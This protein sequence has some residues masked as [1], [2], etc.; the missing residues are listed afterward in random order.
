MP[1]PTLYTVDAG[2]RRDELSLSETWSQKGATPLAKGY[3]QLV[4]VGVGGQN[5]LIGFDAD[6]NG[7]AFRLTGK[8]PWIAPVPSKIS[9]GKADIVEPFIL[10]MAPY[11]LA[12]E[13][14]EGVFSFFPVT[15]DLIAPTPPYKFSHPRVPLTQ[16][17]T[18]TKPIVVNSLLYIL[19]YNYKTGDVDIWSLSVTP[20]PQ[21]GSP[22]GTPPL[23]MLPVWVHQWA[24]SW[25]RFAFFTLGGETFFFKINF[26]PKLNVNIDHVLDDT[27]QGTTE[28]GTWLQN[29]LADPTKIEIAAPLT[30]N[31]GDPYF[32]TYRSNGSTGWFRIHGDCQ[33]WTKAHE[34]TTIKGA[35]QVVPYQIGDDRFALFY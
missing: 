27:T 34:G 3:K 4:T 8:A 15:G 35:T 18:V 30:M 23:L 11:L 22:P 7:S 6:G 5:Y 33:G 25:S 9:V 19:T 2:A 12:Y 10:G 14:R 1:T 28:V 13:A 16:G 31:G 17:F 21:A 26:G 20:T 32:V 24:K 29:L